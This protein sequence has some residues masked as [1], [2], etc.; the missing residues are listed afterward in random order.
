MTTG[1]MMFTPLIIMVMFAP[2]LVVATQYVVGD[3][4]GWTLNYNYA[5]WIN[6]KTFYV[7]DTL[8]KY[9]LIN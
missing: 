6:G 4:S 9:S 8:C 7:G 2:S 3:G 5:N 1:L